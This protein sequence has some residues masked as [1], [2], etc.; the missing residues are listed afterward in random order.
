MHVDLW[1]KPT[2]YCKTITLQVEPIINN[3]QS[4]VHAHLV[5]CIKNS[6]SRIVKDNLEAKKSSSIFFLITEVNQYF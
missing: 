6:D 1:Q 4:L 2:Q 5:N 3:H